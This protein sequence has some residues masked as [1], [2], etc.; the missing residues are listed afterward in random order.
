MIALTSLCG[1]TSMTAESFPSL[2][3]ANLTISHSQG[4]QWRHPSLTESQL[5]SKLYLSQPEGD[6]QYLINVTP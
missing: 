5:K 3:L 2:S 6:R 1:A 4:R